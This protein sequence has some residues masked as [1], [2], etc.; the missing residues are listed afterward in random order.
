MSGLTIL[1]QESKID[2]PIKTGKVHIDGV[3]PQ[4]EDYPSGSFPWLALPVVAGVG[5]G[6]YFVFS[7]PERRKRAIGLAERLNQGVGRFNRSARDKIKG[8]YSRRWQPRRITTQTGSAELTEE[9]ETDLG[10]EKVRLEQRASELEELLQEAG[11][12]N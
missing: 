5:A 8:V 10:K 6:A 9:Y 12:N 11:E 3:P 7:C 1:T 2:V 4:S